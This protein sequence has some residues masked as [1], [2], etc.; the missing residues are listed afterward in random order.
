M[1]EGSIPLEDFLDTMNELQADFER[2]LKG[3]E[4]EASMGA[5][6]VQKRS[7]SA[8]ARTYADNHP[9]LGLEAIW[10]TARRLRDEAIADQEKPFS[11]RH[12]DAVAEPIEE[13]TFSSS[14]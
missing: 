14:R 12:L 1:Y 5:P 11:F 13:E 2:R 8:A 4:R 7:G 6:A 9:P 3:I 10:T